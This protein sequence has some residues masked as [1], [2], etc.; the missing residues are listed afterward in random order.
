M[1]KKIIITTILFPIFVTAPDI[2]PDTDSTQNTAEINQKSL[3]VKHVNEQ[4]ELDA[5]QEAERVKLYQKQG[6]KKNEILAKANAFSGAL[7]DETVKNL[8]IKLDAHAQESDKE[9]SDLQK[10]HDQEK[11]TLKSN[12]QKE[13]ANS[14]SWTNKISHLFSR[15]KAESSNLPKSP[16]SPTL[17]KKEKSWSDSFGSASGLNYGHEQKALKAMQESPEKFAT[18]LDFLKT[19]LEN[20]T[21]EEQLNVLNSW[22][23]I[24]AKRSSR[25]AKAPISASVL[26]SLFDNLNSLLPEDERATFYNKTFHDEI[27][28]TDLLS[29]SVK[30]STIGIAITKTIPLLEKSKAPVINDF[31]HQSNYINNEKFIKE[32]QASLFPKNKSL[33]VKDLK[34]YNTLDRTSILNNW[35]NF[36]Q[37]SYNHSDSLIEENTG[38]KKHVFGKIKQSSVDDANQAKNSLAI[39]FMSGA[40][41]MLVNVNEILPKSQTL[42]LT[43]TK[44]KPV[45]TA[46]LFYNLEKA[47]ENPESVAKSN[48]DYAKEFNPAKFQFKIIST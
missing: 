34:N 22:L 37:D 18:N 27:S 40:K 3:D 14:K 1:L 9:E 31:K 44:G 29:G 43:D 24:Y 32:N 12:Q 25:F 6:Q 10:Q 28:T 38:L 42:I 48:F 46:D 7:D 41:D 20:L 45:N 35:V 33:L 39:K 26:K 15:D 8:K 4:K 5:Q 23:S 2:I 21:R 16:T 36:W 47:I 19:N 11:A 30:A 13:I 17:S